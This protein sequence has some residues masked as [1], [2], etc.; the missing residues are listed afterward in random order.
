MRAASKT[1]MDRIASGMQVG[2][3]APSVFV[4]VKQRFWENRDIWNDSLIDPEQ[5][6]YQL[7]DRVSS[8][9]VQEDVDQLASSFT[10]TFSNEQGQ[11][12]PDNYTGKFPQDIFFEPEDSR[13]IYARQLHQNNEIVLYL[14]YGDEVVPFIH[15]WTGEVKMTA[16]GQTIV[17]SC[18]TS[19][20]HI[21]HQTINEDKIVAPDGNLYDVL[22]FFFDHAGVKL[23][24][25]KM[26]V[27]GTDEEWIIEKATGTRGQAYDEVVRE[28]ID[29]TFHYLRPEIDGSCTLM[30]T[31]KYMFEDDADTIFDEGVNLTAL[32]YS[33]TDTDVYNAVCVKSG[34]QT[35]RY[36]NTF[37]YEDVLL[38]RWNEEVVDVPWANTYWKRREVAIASHVRNM[39]NWRIL[40]VGVVGDPRLQLWDRVG[41]REQS[42][43]VTWNWH[44]KGIQTMLD[45]ESGFF[46]TLDLAI[47]YGYETIPQP[48]LTG[49]KVSVSKIRLKVWDWM[50]QDGDAMN[51]YANNVRV[52][53]NYKLTN[54]PTYIE[55]PLKLGDNHIVF[56]AITCARGFFTGRL[57]VLDVSNN[58]IFDVGSLP[59]I[60][61]A[62]A[63]VDKNGVYKK[64]PTKTW[65]VSR[66]N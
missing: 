10:I 38:K 19:Y 34:N 40:T 21:L 14:G 26:F 44:I 39:H 61:F 31:P 32:E 2:A 52:A 60:T 1:L 20:K 66:I 65:V 5:K 16:D 13:M 46:Q 63:G 53:S 57:Q 18:M 36:N 12:A 64:K 45:S 56:E 30:P 28:L 29:T 48:E 9:E 62:R 7:S 47:N 58:I 43:S 59:D 42:S 8:V 11:L 37:L 22:K 4:Y 54:N 6:W 23:N 41:V 35:S 25:E 51:V 50:V 3:S 27:P 24:G 33:V 55:I 17:V 49:V 15:G